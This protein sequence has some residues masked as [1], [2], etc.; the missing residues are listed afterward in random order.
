M[1]V[2]YA[3]VPLE[4]IYV[5]TGQVFTVFA[6]KKPELNEYFQIGIRCNYNGEVEIF[7]DE[8]KTKPFSEWTNKE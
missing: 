5:G 1:N 2:P 8:L 7:C 3:H 4:K 6:H